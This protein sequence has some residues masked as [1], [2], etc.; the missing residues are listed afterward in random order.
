MFNIWGIWAINLQHVEHAQHVQNV[1]N[2]CGPLAGWPKGTVNI[3]D[4]QDGLDILGLLN[5]GALNLQDG[6]HDQHGGRPLAG[7]RQQNLSML[8]ILNV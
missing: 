1:Q 7:D 4:T 5:I 2:V 3:L 6:Q 8:S